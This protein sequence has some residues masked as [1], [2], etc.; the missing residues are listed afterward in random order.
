MKSKLTFTVLAFTLIMCAGCGHPPRETITQPKPQEE[1]PAPAIKVYI[2]NSG[3]MNGYVEGATDFENAVYSYL[4][5]LQLANLGTRT[6]EDSLSFKNRMELNFI[7]SCISP[8]EAS[9]IIEFIKKLEPKVFRDDAEKHGGDLGTSDISDIIGKILDNLKDDEIAILVSDCI[10]SPGKE[11]K[12]KDN[13]DDYLVAQQIGIKNHVAK[14]MA[15]NPNISFVMMRLLSQ[16]NGNYYNKFDDSIGLKN[17]KRPFYIWLM[18]DS[19]YLKKI[20]NTVDYHKIKG[21]GV[22]NIYAISSAVQNLN[23]GILDQPRIGKFSR[24]K[25]A[26]KTS[27]V[28]AKTEN[29]GGEPQFQLSIGVDYSNLLL[30]DEYLLDSMNYNISN[31]SYSLKVTKN[32]N[33]NPNQSSS[34]THI[35]KLTLKQPIISKGIVKISLL[36]NM[37][38]WIYAFNDEDG[39][40]INADRAMEKTYGLKYLA[41]G[42]Y[43]AFAK[44]DKYATITINI[45]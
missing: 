12:V 38:K 24:D 10:F 7:N 42:V 41:E 6:R 11:Y 13:A 2:E 45:N 1:M 25:A 3:S 39:S 15:A 43:D 27:I 16:F 9:D 26:S 31:D 40:N 37:P 19:K 4:S 28:N 36:N 20:M 17:V 35:I 5:D 18:G 29:R 21:G 34:Y 23:Y 33:K 32:P 30:E 8:Q 44:S 22:Q 14:K